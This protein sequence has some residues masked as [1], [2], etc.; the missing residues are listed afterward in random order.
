MNAADFAGEGEMATW[1]ASETPVR[2]KPQRGS[3]TFIISS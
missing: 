3:K 2:Y 1:V